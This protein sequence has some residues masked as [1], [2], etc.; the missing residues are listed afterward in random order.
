LGQRAADA[1]RQIIE[2]V[3][4]AHALP[5]ARAALAHA[6]QREQDPL[7]ILDL[8]EGRRALGTVP[9]AAAGMARIAFELLDDARFLVHVR[10]Q[11]ARRLA[12]EARGGHEAVVPTALHPVAP[13]FDG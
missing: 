7:G 10:E 4:P 1:A 3:V 2:R 8:I 6:L 5:L 12:V 9:A 11:S 13:P